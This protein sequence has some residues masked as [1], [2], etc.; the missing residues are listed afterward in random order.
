MSSE[1]IYENFRNILIVN[2]NSVI[3][4]QKTL[5]DVVKMVDVSMENFEIS[6]RSVEI[7]P[8]IGSPEVVKCYL[9]SKA[10]ANVSK[11]TLKQYH[12]KLVH[13]FNTIRKSYMDI[14]ANDIR[15]YLYNFKL[16][17]NASDHYVDNVRVSLNSF[18]KWLVDNE[19]IQRNPCAKVDKIKYTAKQREPLTSIQLETVRFNTETV[20]EKAVIDFLFSTGCRV[21][22]CADVRLSDINWANRSVHIRHG[23]GDKERTV[24]FNAESELTMKEYIKSRTDNNDALF[25]SS[26]LPHQQLKSHAIE[27]IVKKIGERA[28]VKVYPHKLRHTFATAGLRGGMPLEKLQA[29]MGHAAPET[30][31]IYAKLSRTDLQTEHS[32]VYA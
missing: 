31:L 28:G 32:R 15:L 21:S 7:I 25:V 13:F 14:T 23:K 8:V 10:I 12:Y 30:T 19:Y 6:K 16:E 5:S 18:F 3:Q 2:L 29:L 24:F 4:D 11:G 27:N 1:N 9:A 20:R 26:K 22:E 17:R